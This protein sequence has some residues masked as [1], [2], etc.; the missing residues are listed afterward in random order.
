M[1]LMAAKIQ[2]AQLLP[3]VPAVKVNER[4][5]AQTPGRQIVMSVYY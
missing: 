2:S 5:G 4:P 1:E 3:P